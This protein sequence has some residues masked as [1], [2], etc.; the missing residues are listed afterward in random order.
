MPVAEWFRGEL[1]EFAHDAVFERADEILNRHVPD[2]VLEPASARTAGLV[3]AAVVRPDVQDL[4][5]GRQG[6]MSGIC[7]VWRK[8]NPARL[9]ADA[10]GGQPRP[11]APAA[12][13]RLLRESGSRPRASP[14]PRAFATQQVFRKRAPAAGLRRRS[15]RRRQTVKHPDGGPLGAAV[16]ASPAAAFVEKLRGSFSIVLWDRRERKLLAAVDGFGINRLVYFENAEMLLVASRLDALLVRAGRFHG[17]QSAGD[18]ELSEFRREPG[19]GNDF[20]QRAAAAPGHSAGGVRRAARASSGIGTCATA[21]GTI[22]TKTPFEPRAGR[23]GRASP[24]QRTARA[25]TFSRSR[26][27][28]E[29][30]DRQQHRGGNDE[31]AGPRAG[32]GVLHRL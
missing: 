3:G 20:P 23:R 15:L 4:A 7:A 17:C 10:G 26:R 27:L 19:A 11:R 5:G 13:E 24:W 29:R 18:R 30:R 6:R 14:S 2:A 28:P 12:D 31:P 16:R 8:D 9:S 32:E 25:V 22:R 1:K 21:P